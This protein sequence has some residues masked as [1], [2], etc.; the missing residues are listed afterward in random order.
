MKHS[1]K[2]WFFAT[3]FWSF[4][5]P[6]MPV[7]VTFAYLCSVGAVAISG[8]LLVKFV[9]ALLGVVSLHAAGNLLSDWFDFRS[10]VDNE[11]A[12]AVENLVFGRFQPR[13]YLIFSIILF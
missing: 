1:V 3:R 7:V 8:G 4:P 5:V 9:L 11:K 13:E 6:L 12:F 2:E 10:G